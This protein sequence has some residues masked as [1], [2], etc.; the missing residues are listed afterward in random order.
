MRHMRLSLPILAALALT[1]CA[2][3]TTALTSVQTSLTS[4]QV[5]VKDATTAVADYGVAKGI[6]LPL[7]NLFPA[8]IAPANA[9]FAVADPLMDKI[10]AGASAATIDI[11]ALQSLISQLQAQTLAIRT[12]A[13]QT[14]PAAPPVP[15][16]AAKPTT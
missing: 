2:G 3:T 13:V 10:S 4:A 1:G 5:I 7:L 9:L 14:S 15:A 16:Q 8:A 12:L 11:A 6:V